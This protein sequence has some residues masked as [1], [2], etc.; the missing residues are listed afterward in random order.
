MPPCRAGGTPP[1]PSPARAAPG[2][3]RPPGRAVRPRARTVPRRTPGAAAAPPPTPREGGQQVMAVVRQLDH[4]RH[5]VRRAAARRSELPSRVGPHHPLDLEAHLDVESVVGRLRRGPP[6][7][8]AL[9]TGVLVAV[10]GEPV[11]RR[12][13]PAR[14]RRQAHETVE[15]RVQPQVSTGP[16]GDPARR[17]A[18]V[19]AEHV[20]HRRHADTPTGGV[21]QPG[22]RHRLHPR[23]TCV[24]DVA[25]RDPVDPVL[26]QGSRERARPALL[27]LTPPR[28]PRLTPWLRLEPRPRPAKAA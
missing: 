8:A 9:T 7:E 26:G 16:T 21:R 13:R 1:A 27:L 11:H 6:G 25:Q 15:V 18:V 14:L 19:D 17:D 2:P 3:R 4:P 20:E 24:V 10:L 12:P 28:C 22:H 5:A 23:D